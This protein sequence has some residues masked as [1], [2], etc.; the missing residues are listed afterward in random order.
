M[1]APHAH[2]RVVVDARD[3]PLRTANRTLIYHMCGLFNF[4]YSS[5]ISLARGL[6]GECKIYTR[7]KSMCVI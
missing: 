4:Y 2:R 7:S 5:L 3:A 6:S 1:R